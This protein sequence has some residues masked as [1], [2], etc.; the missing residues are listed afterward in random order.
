MRPFRSCAMHF[1]II[2]GTVRLLWT[3]LWDRYHV[4]R[5]VGLFLVF[6][7]F[8][9]RKCNL[10][11]AATIGCSTGKVAICGAKPVECASFDAREQRTALVVINNVRLRTSCWSC[12]LSL[13]VLWHD[14]ASRTT[15]ARSRSRSVGVQSF[16][17]RLSVHSP[18]TTTTVHLPSLLPLSHSPIWHYS[19][20]NKEL[21]LTYF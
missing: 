2:I 3:W 20:V 5:N 13:L 17:H 8:L 12:S 10:D 15:H 1:A 18:N 21:A 9:H 14:A 4:P 16:V 19:N 11:S 7:K 6:F